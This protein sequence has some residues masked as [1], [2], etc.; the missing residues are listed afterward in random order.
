MVEQLAQPAPVPER[1]DESADQREWHLWAV[2][3]RH[4]WQESQRRREALIRLKAID[5]DLQNLVEVDDHLERLHEQAYL[6]RVQRYNAARAWR[7]STNTKL[8]DPPFTMAR[9]LTTDH[10]QLFLY[11][12]AA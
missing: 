1:P 6:Q 8:T 7:S 3:A 9:G 4:A 10:P 12:T 11:P 5:A 2:E